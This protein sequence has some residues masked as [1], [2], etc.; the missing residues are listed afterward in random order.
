MLIKRF[1]QFLAIASL[2]AIII[3]VSCQP[4]LAVSPNKGDITSKNAN[5][6]D[7][8]S[9]S[10]KTKSF[11]AD[12][13]FRPE[14]NGFS[15]ENYGNEGG[16]QNLKTADMQRMFGNQVCATTGDTC[17]LTPPAEQWMEETNKGMNGGH[18]EGMAA[19]SLIL[20]GDKAKAGELGNTPDIALQGNEKVQREIAYWFATQGVAP[21]STNEIKDKTP[22]ELLDI[23]LSSLQPNTSINQTYTMGIYQPEFKGGHAITPYAIADMGDGKYTVMVYDNNHPKLERQVEID[24]NANTWKYVASTKPG[25]AESE[26]AGDAGTKTLTLTPTK[27]RYEIQ[28]CSFC[29]TAD[30]STSEKN[31][32]GSTSKAVQFNQIFLEGDADLLISNGNQKIGYENGKFV[33]AFPGATFIPMKS[34]E[35]WKDDEEPLYNIPVGVPFTMTLQASSESQGKELTDVVMIGHGYDLGV[36]GIKVL[37]GQKDSIKFD[38]SGRSLSYKPSNPEA[39]NI[40]FGISTE[41][42]DYEFELD[43]VEI[44]AGGTIS[45][46]LDTAKGRLG[47]KIADSKQAAIF[48]L[49]ISR[50]DDKTEQNFEGED[51]T[52][53]S[54]DTM[55][56]DYAKWTG[57][58]AKLTIELDNGS[59]G[60]IDETTTVDDKK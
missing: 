57:N 51:L 59:D 6:S 28:E 31:D 19:L 3:L 25:E 11:V 60:T 22:S 40:A 56:L 32:K 38:A 15:F 37:P 58:G 46:N 14:A 20:Y 44:D 10:S 27:P 21:T 30:Q 39:P 36:E 34:N 43:Q 48:N 9:N 13:G 24:R 16:I 17:I 53:N 23:L 45:A 49:V 54:G 8:D 42:D 55:Y 1:L 18:C 4:N 7:S 33:N 2:S 26:Y 50:I 12:L 35:L 52:L 5:Y 41:K 47:I 29:G